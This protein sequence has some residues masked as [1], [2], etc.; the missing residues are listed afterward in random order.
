MFKIL[1]DSETMTQFKPD[2]TSFK[3]CLRMKDPIVPE[4]SILYYQEFFATKS[5]W[6]ARKEPNV[7]L[8]KMVIIKLFILHSQKWNSLLSER[9]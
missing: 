5:T 2:S 7:T 6:K 9:F 4:M 8:K 3:K 1:N